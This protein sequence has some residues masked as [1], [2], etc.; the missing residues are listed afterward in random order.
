MAKNGT[1]EVLQGLWPAPALIGL[2]VRPVPQRRPEFLLQDPCAPSAAAVQGYAEG[3][4]QKQASSGGSRAGRPQV[5]PGLCDSQATRRVRAERR[6]AL[7]S[8]AILQAV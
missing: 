4:A 7:R 3:A 6:Y 2:H 1:R 5:V 8:G